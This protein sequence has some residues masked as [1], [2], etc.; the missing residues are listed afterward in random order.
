MSRDWWGLSP[1]A[2]AATA[3]GWTRAVQGRRSADGTLQQCTRVASRKSLLLGC[4]ESMPIS[5]LG[6]RLDIAETKLPVSRRVPNA[7]RLKKWAREVA[8]NMGID[9]PAT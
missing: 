9:C 6:F 4:S 3:C 8:A 7:E 2:P 5:R 1:K